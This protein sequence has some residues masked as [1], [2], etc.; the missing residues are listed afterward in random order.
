MRLMPRDKKVY[1]FLCQTKMPMSTSAIAKMFYLQNNTMT[2]AL[3]IA[4]RRLNKMVEEGYI[5][6]LNRKFGEKAI[7]YCGKQPN[8]QQL[9]HKI[10]MTDFIAELV[11]N[12]F[13]V[14]DC[15]FEY[16]LP[17]KYGIRSDIFLTIEY[18]SKFYYLFV[19]V[20]LTKEFNKKYL[21]LI[22]DIEKG[23]F[24]TK[25]PVFIVSISDFKIDNEE[26]RKNVI[27]ID[28]ELSNFNKILWKFIK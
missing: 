3:V 25:Y 13:K 9:R 17:E 21:E 6:R 19:E 14:I 12:Q 7:Y 22:Q 16:A 4:N 23:L 18:N 2:S 20:D 8:K 15:R 5:D 28:T 24:R 27:Q 10:I 1:Q 11:S 26:I